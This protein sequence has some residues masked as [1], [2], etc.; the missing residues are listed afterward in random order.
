MRSTLVA[1]S[2]LQHLGLPRQHLE[3]HKRHIVVLGDIAD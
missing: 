3:R 2:M 1:F